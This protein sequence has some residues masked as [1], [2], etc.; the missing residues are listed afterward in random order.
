LH[1]RPGIQL[2]PVEA[3][4]LFPLPDLREFRA[5]ER[6]KPIPGDAEVARGVLHADEP[7]R[8]L[9]RGRLDMDHCAHGSD[10]ASACTR[11]K[12]FF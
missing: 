3:E 4:G 12:R 6:V 10:R 2:E 11:R 8:G 9:G 5:D 1:V 7:R